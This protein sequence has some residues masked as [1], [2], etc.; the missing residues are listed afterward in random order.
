LKLETLLQYARKYPE[1]TSF[2]IMNG[3]PPFVNQKSRDIEKAFW[4]ENASKDRK[5][6]LTNKWKG[7]SRETLNKQMGTDSGTRLYVLD[8]PKL[9]YDFNFDAT[10]LLKGTYWNMRLWSHIF[11]DLMP[12][13]D[14]SKGKTIKVPV[15]L[16]LGKEDYYVPFTLWNDEKGK[17]PNLS[18]NLFE[19]SGHYPFF[20]EEELFRTKL[21]AWIESLK[22]RK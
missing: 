12:D 3:T 20:E 18:F 4:E 2:V 5:L 8:G 7:V 13:F 21:I 15:F 1:H 9:W 11:T 19:K 17:I 22:V 10:K 14:L 6:A 16:S